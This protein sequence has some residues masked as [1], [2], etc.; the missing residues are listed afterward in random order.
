MRGKE[1]K[2]G[3]LPTVEGEKKEA[4]CR[5]REREKRSCGKC[6]YSRKREKEVGRKWKEKRAAVSVDI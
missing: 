4:A 3:V 2:K 1:R 6:R 5:E